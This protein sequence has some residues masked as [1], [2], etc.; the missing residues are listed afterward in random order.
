MDA[1][2][3]ILLYYSATLPISQATF[4]SMAL[5]LLLSSFLL[6]IQ[7]W[8]KVTYTFTRDSSE[9]EGMLMLWSIF[10]HISIIMISTFILWNEWFY[11]IASSNADVVYGW[12][13]HPR[14]SITFLFLPAKQHEKL[15]FKDSIEMTTRKK[16]WLR[17][18]SI[19]MKTV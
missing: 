4:S 7:W 12:M 6:F 1:F 16:E 3:R 10:T 2:P 19:T 9:W 18:N 11:I 13:I 5:L 14:L 17:K 8:E 15:Y